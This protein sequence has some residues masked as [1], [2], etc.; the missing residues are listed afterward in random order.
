M[1]VVI[2]LNLAGIPVKNMAPTGFDAWMQAATF[3][4]VGLVAVYTSGMTQR[5]SILVGLI[6]ASVVYAIPHQRHGMGKP[7]DVSGIAMPP[8]SARR[9]SP[10]RYSTPRPCC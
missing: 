6:L 9:S 8:G 1:V 10:R 5:L 7:I 3:V 4:C 2:G